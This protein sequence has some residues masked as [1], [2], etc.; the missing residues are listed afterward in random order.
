MFPSQMLCLKIVE[1]SSGKLFICFNRKWYALKLSNPQVAHFIH[2]SLANGTPSNCRTLKW[3]TLSMF[4]SQMV[5]L[6]IVEPSSFPLY[7]CFP[8]KWYALKLSNRQVAHF[9]HVS[10]ANGMP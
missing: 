9:V 10:L 4:N 2:V 6:K 8:R 7:P 3:P 5:C 1:S